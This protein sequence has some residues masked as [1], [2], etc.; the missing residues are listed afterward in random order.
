VAYGHER[1]LIPQRPSVWPLIGVVLSV[2]ALGLA[3]RAWLRR[4]EAAAEA[5]R[6]LRATDGAADVR[7]FKPSG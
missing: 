1:D 6:P 7:P 4:G 2:T 3:L 5:D